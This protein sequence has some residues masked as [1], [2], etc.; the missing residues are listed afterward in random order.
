M[1]EFP[2]K[3]LKKVQQRKEEGAFRN[4]MPPASGI[5]FSSNDYLGFA[6]SEKENSREYA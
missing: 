1:E 5:D 6:R 4:L 3:L 2:D